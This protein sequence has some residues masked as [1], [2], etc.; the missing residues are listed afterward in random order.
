MSGWIQAAMQ[1]STITEGLEN[2]PF[3][4]RWHQIQKHSF[5]IKLKSALAI[6][7]HFTHNV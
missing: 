6:I 4:E 1:Q 2:T 5:R 3:K 7:F